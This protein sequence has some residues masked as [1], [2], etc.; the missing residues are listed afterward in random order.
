MKSIA[1]FFFPP[2]ELSKPER[3]LVY[4]IFFFL[5]KAAPR[6]NGHGSPHYGKV[7]NEPLSP[8]FLFFFSFA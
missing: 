5:V 7:L 6:S 3:L 2:I 1:L 8:P 4:P